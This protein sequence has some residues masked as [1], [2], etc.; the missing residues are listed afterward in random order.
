MQDDQLTIHW[1]KS[2]NRSPDQVLGRSG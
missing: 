1:Q 2:T